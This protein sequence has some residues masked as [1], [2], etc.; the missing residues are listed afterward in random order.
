M[1]TDILIC[2]YSKKKRRLE[3]MRGTSKLDRISSRDDVKEVSAVGGGCSNTWR[4]TMDNGDVIYITA[5]IFK[6]EE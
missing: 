4:F 1:I 6:I 5:D 2:T 3:I